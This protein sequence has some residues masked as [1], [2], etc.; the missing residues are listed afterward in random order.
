MFS[1]Q[2]AYAGFLTGLAM[3]MWL[4]IG[5]QVYKP[6]V[7]K[8]PVSTTGCPVDNTTTWAANF[9]TELYTTTTEASVPYYEKLVY[10]VASCQWRIYMKKIPEAPAN[11]T[12]FFRFY[13]VFPKKHLPQSLAT[14]P[15]PT[16]VGAPHRKS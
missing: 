9:T 6:D 7:L 15:L 1:I 4:G 12:Q 14:S 5:A 8:P 3:T 10:L 11:R 16:R 13:T 2:G